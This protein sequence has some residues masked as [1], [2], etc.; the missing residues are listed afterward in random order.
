METV[1]HYDLYGKYVRII[2]TLL[3]VCQYFWCDHMVN[4][5]IQYVSLDVQK[6]SGNLNPSSVYRMA[7]L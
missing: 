4:V 5:H 6:T 1:H 3:Y 2:T 7:K